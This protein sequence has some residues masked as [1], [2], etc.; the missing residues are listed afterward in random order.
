MGDCIWALVMH[1][2]PVVRE[3]SFDFNEPWSEPPVGACG[4]RPSDS[5]TVESTRSSYVFKPIV[6][7]VAW[8]T[9]SLGSVSRRASDSRGCGS[10]QL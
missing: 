6:S 10:I 2:A 3:V 8:F 7:R 4:H 9:S 1:L 5:R